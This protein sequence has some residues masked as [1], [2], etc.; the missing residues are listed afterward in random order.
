[1]ELE[2]LKDL[3]QDKPISYSRSELE[4]IFSIKTK[5]ELDVVNKKMRWDMVLMVITAIV[6]IGIA[7]LLGL[8]DRFSLS[9]GVILLVAI[10][11]IHYRIKYFDISK[12]NLDKHD[13][14]TAIQ[15]VVKSLRF[16]LNLYKLVVPVF[17]MSFYSYQRWKLLQIKNTLPSSITEVLVESALVI[18]V[19]LVVYFLTK[20][21]SDRLYGKALIRMQDYLHKLH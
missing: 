14:S 18:T 6:I 5:R 13:L 15:N 19:G 7:F 20:W 17:A 21:I 9:A 10:I 12:V 3:V 1:M 2:E 8:R 4:S 16:Y 11:S